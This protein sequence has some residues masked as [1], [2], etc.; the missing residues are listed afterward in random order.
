MCEDSYWLADMLGEDEEDEHLVT[1]QS[2]SV[3]LLSCLPLSTG[4]LQMPTEENELVGYLRSIYLTP[5]DPCLLELEAALPSDGQYHPSTTVSGITRSE[6]VTLSVRDVWQ[7]WQNND[8]SLQGEESI[9]GEFGYSPLFLELLSPIGTESVDEEHTITLGKLVLE[10]TAAGTA[11][12]FNIR[13]VARQFGTTLSNLKTPLYSLLASSKQYI[14]VSLFNTGPSQN[15]TSAV[16]CARETLLFGLDRVAGATQKMR[17]YGLLGLSAASSTAQYSYVCPMRLGVDPS[18]WQRT[19]FCFACSTPFSF[20]S[21]RHSC[22]KCGHSFC[23]QHSS[24]RRALPPRY[25]YCVRMCDVCAHQQDVE[26]NQVLRMQRASRVGAYLLGNLTL[27]QP[28][29]FDPVWAKISRG[30]EGLLHA[31]RHTLAVTSYPT[32]VVVDLL[33]ILS[34]H[35]ATGEWGPP[36]SPLPAHPSLSIYSHHPSHPPHSPS[37]SPTQLTHPQKGVIGLAHSG[38]FAVAL[39]QLQKIGGIQK[40][41]GLGLHSLTAAVVY[42]LALDRRERGCAPEQ[43]LEEHGGCGLEPWTGDSDF[44]N[45]QWAG[46]SDCRPL[47]SAV[48]SETARLAPLALFAIYSSS[49]VEVQQQLFSAGF[50]LIYASLESGLDKPSFALCASRRQGLEQELGK[51]AVLVIRGTHSLE[52]FLTDLRAQPVKYPPSASVVLECLQPGGG[53]SSVALRDYMRCCSSDEEVGES[54]KEAS[55]EFRPDEANGDDWEWLQGAASDAIG[56]TY[57]CKGMVAAALYL[58]QSVGPDLIRLSSLGFKVTIIGHS[59]GGAVAALLVPLLKEHA[60]GIKGIGF[61]NPCCSDL[62]TA[63][64]LREDFTTVVLGDDVCSRI[65][66]T[67]IRRLL[68]E[69]SLLT[70]EG[71]SLLAEDAGDVARRVSEVW[72]PFERGRRATA[73]CATASLSHASGP[74]SIIPPNTRE[75]GEKFREIYLPGSVVHLYT[76]RGLSLGCQTPNTLPVLRKITLSENMFDDHLGAPMYEA[77]KSAIG[78]HKYR[79]SRN[80]VGPNLVPPPWARHDSA[81]TCSLCSESFTWNSTFKS[82]SSQFRNT[83]NCGKCGALVCEGCSRRQVPVGFGCEAKTRVCDSCF[84][85]L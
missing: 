3:S 54:E 43:A 36:Q 21:F 75:S 5:D 25:P 47:S 73:V 79:C 60:P 51:E 72:R 14:P 19:L 26:M 44:T 74:T 55:D 57:A 4:Q 76:Y 27:L 77:L 85:K 29:N 41:E 49:V 34:K 1:G 50:A 62:S 67:S 80:H 78:G 66:P 45:V 40:G 15:W 17:H 46:D 18:E 58:L 11:L 38:E 71:C 37:L 24:Q 20:T 61:G 84:Y 68:D 42:K 81:A 10:L 30:C 52:D 69:L 64:A 12:L 56:P 23:D 33:T 28:L 31:I 83:H 6:L 53:T 65:N 7:E 59:L 13:N 16:K 35:G 82:S 32:R 2:K 48:L 8:I 39:Q 9:G 22:R 70:K 63:L